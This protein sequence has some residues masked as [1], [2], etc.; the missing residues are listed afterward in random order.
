[1]NFFIV[2]SRGDLEG[3]E[4]RTKKN[5]N[6]QSQNKVSAGKMK[7]AKTKYYERKFSLKKFEEW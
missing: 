5:G 3:E 4:L 2:K 6:I 1:M 7:S